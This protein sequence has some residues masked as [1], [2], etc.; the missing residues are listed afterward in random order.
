MMRRLAERHEGLLPL[1]TV[2]GIWRV[3][4]ATFTYVQA[5]LR[6]ACRHLGRRCGDA[7]FRPLPFRLHRALRPHES[8][9]R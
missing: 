9:A 3:I 7:R 1:D 4:I 6:R 2:E 8:A 5:P